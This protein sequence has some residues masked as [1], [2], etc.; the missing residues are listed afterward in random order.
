M[1]LR[2]IVLL[3]VGLIARKMKSANDVIFLTDLQREKVEKVL[4]LVYNSNSIIKEFFGVSSSFDV[5]ICRG[6]WEMELQNVS[7]RQDLLVRNYDVTRSTITDHHLKEIVI[8]YDTARFGDY[9]YGFI[10]GILS[11]VHTQ[12][13]KEGLAWH[14]T[15][16]LTQS[17]RYVRP[18]CPEWIEHYCIYPVNKLARIVGDDF[19]KDFALG[20]ASI[21]E[22]LLPEDIRQL[23]LPEE[24]FYKN[25]TRFHS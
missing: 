3:K 9:L 19:L 5:V 13:L 14:F 1:Y 4:M 22:E 12:Q 15:L 20:R 8:R 17:Y 18:I 23:F 6:Y 25:K 21:Q 7:R 10:M 11:N 2:S 24:Y 16:H